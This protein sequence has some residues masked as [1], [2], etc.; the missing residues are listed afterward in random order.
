MEKKQLFKKTST[1]TKANLPFVSG[2]LVNGS[3]SSPSIHRREF[4]SMA[5]G[6]TVT[7]IGAGAALPFSSS[8]LA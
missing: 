3:A 7:A 6:A 2:E 8:L 4:I 5:G 1:Q